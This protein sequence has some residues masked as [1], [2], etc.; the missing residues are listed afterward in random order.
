MSSNSSSSGPS[1]LSRC[2]SSW[3]AS[4]RDRLTATGLHLS[5]VCLGGG[6]GI[7]RAVD[8]VDQRAG[9]DCA[10]GAELSDAAD[11]LGLR[12]AEADDERRFAFG[13]HTLEEL[14]Q[15]GGE[16]LPRASYADQG[17]AVNEGGIKRGH[18]ANAGGG[19]GRRDQ[20]GQAEAV[21]F[22]RCLELA[23][24][25]G[26]QVGNDNCVGFGG[27]ELGGDALVAALSQWVVVGHER[28]W[29]FGCAPANRAHEVQRG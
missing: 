15:R 5:Q 10:G 14:A 11:V 16:V 12:N 26:G 25:L 28:D 6:D 13:A 17:D 29:R 9:D 19:T 27:G 22:Q 20:R 8:Q 23:G 7:W 24:F 3:R 1:K 18:G 2:S 21:G 4:A